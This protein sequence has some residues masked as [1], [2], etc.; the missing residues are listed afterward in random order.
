MP[1]PSGW[2]DDD[3]HRG[4]RRRD[5]VPVDGPS[6]YASGRAHLDALLDIVAARTAL[7]IADSWNSG[8]L[9]PH[10]ATKRPH[11]LEVDALIGAVP[12]FA[13]DKLDQTRARLAAAEKEAAARVLASTAAGV[14]LPFPTLVREMKLSPVAAQVLL[15]V[16][17]GRR[18]DRTAR[19]VRDRSQ[20]RLGGW[21]SR[22]VARRRR[23]S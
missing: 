3:H 12:G 6:P 7:V 19:R 20:R 11:E 18:R 5:A 16:R 4:A 17:I 22:P 15:V 8:R 1:K 14:R 23:C 10:N 9:S 13:G 2:P 21:P